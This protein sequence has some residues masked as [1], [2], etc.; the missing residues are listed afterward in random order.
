MAGLMERLHLGD[1]LIPA[2]RSQLDGWMAGTTTGAKRLPAALPPGWRIGHK[3]GTG[4]RG[5]TNDVAILWPS[6]RSPV[7][8][9]AYFAESSSAIGK[10][11]AAIAEAGRAVLESLG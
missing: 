8:I 6:N 4:Q 9:A 11:E 3:T 1:A 10:R 5:A 2:S 7:L